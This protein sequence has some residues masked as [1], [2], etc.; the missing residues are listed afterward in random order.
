MYIHCVCTCIYI[1]VCIVHDFLCSIKV[2]DFSKNFKCLYDTY[3]INTIHLNAQIF[4][5]KLSFKAMCVSQHDSYG[6]REIE[7]KREG[8]S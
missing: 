8:Q 2:F 5:L 7:E 6:W 3:P 4:K 1:Y